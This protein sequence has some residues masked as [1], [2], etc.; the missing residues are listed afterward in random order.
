MVVTLSACSG[1]P[2]PPPDPGQV[3][4]A[5]GD[6]GAPVAAPAS[7]FASGRSALAEPADV[8]LD[9][10]VSPMPGGR[11]VLLASQWSNER[12]AWARVLDG[13]TGQSTAPVRFTGEHVLTAF[14]WASTSP[15]KAPT[16]VTSDGARLCFTDAANPG[17]PHCEV[18]SP[19]VVL[20][21]GDRIAMLE[22]V[23]AHIPEPAPP[24]G[25]APSKPPPKP[26]RPAKPQPAKK[27]SKPAAQ[28]KH[29]PARRPSHPL[30]ELRV[31]F[32]DARGTF[33]PEARPTG[34][35]FEAPIDGM[36][37][38]DARA[39]TLPGAAG[40][41]PT[42]LLD[43]L[44]YET[45]PKRKARKG[46][47]LGSARLMA[48]SLKADGSLDFS[49]RVPV[50]DGD[51]EY[52]SLKDHRFPRLY[53]TDLATVFLDL[54]KA[55]HC[56]SFR[57]LPTHGFL[58]QTQTPVAC[59]L[60]PDQL[61][62]ASLDPA[63]VTALERLYREEPRRAG[64][65]PR[66]DP[67]LVA[68]A[69]DRAYYRHA[70]P[71]GSAT[72]R[73][74]SR[75]DGVPRD[76]PAPFVAKRSRVSWGAFFPDGEG[77]AFSQ[78]TLVHVAPDGSLTRG[79]KVEG[80]LASL[81]VAPEEHADRRRVARIGASFFLARGPLTGGALPRLWPEDPAGRAPL[82][83]AS[84]A[85]SP[86]TAVLAGGSSEGLLLDLA[87]T[88]LRLSTV[89]PEG[90]V[91]PLGAPRLSPVR[92]GFDA[93]ERLSN[94]SGGAL[95]A[96]VSAQ[97]PAKVVA[98]TVDARGALGTAFPVPLP[99]K[100]GEIGVRLI[101]LPAGGALLTDLDRRHVVWLDDS[102]HPIGAAP[103]PL[104]S[105]DAACL[106]GRPARL[107]VPDPT[108]GELTRI[109]NAERNEC[110][111]GDAVWAS[112]G[113]LRWFGSLVSG[114]D[115]LA[116]VARVPLRSPSIAPAL[117]LPSN[118]AA[119]APLPNPTG[120]PASPCPGD[121][122]SIAGRFCID[123][124]EGMAVDAR[125]GEALSPDYPA[126][127][128]LLDF[129][130]AEWSTNHERVG[131][132][133]AR[134]LPLP[135]IAP[136]RIG[137]KTEPVI[138]SR[139]GVRPSGYLTGVVADAACAAAGKRLCKLEEFNTACRGEEDRQF[140]Y[141]DD[142]QDGV[143]NVFREEHPAALL[144]NNASIGHL[145]PRLNRV[146]SKGRPMLE[147]T[148]DRAVC[149]SRWGNDAVYD[150]VGNMDEWIDEGTGAFAGGFY[151]RS[152]R[153][154]CDAVI[155]AHPKGYLDYSTGVRCCKGAGR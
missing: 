58:A 139:L 74:A 69:G 60:A 70:G 43:V 2:R 141:G 72:L 22:V 36:T 124:F 86:D 66:G 130:L 25:A 11:S 115:S 27:G 105:S 94:G 131:N 57:I 8:A 68:W 49:S 154:G 111:T 137:Q 103:W 39:R 155:T 50:L 123:R 37:L 81:L 152:T 113:S 47:S 89:T 21:T 129:A 112:D 104:E 106:D 73:S 44:W 1:Q 9:F 31:R 102:G 52:G 95:V 67:G 10:T 18:A 62:L 14:D 93:C 91:A 64:G 126:T 29:G 45:A 42:S 133:H 114:L 61:T 120:A 48:G 90:R 30:V 127:P 128:G 110:L 6:A 78:G 24:K 20:P 54:D 79:A 117:G 151:A 40:A 150:M 147:R 88:A 98:F 144:H 149:R 77:L 34:L 143:C 41:A 142:Y 135:F 23:T 46:A 59:S 96:G 28:P 63:D 92:A 32:G 15:E 17:S 4:A 109:P 65:Q 33:E 134:A 145:D 138:V 108:P 118:A 125:T 87:G 148:G 76:E 140:P 153:A 7:P 13:R 101:P 97:D 107:V 53:G 75:R 56:E 80:P 51:L 84:P 122:V 71:G 55:G 83:K 146:L 5:Q 82:A 3:L 119:L 116:E 19:T 85:L 132:A 38:V 136:A 12:L 121:M 26:S 100:A 99:I 16:L 35:H